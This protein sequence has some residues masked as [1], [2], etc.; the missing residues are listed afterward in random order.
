M[1]WCTDKHE[2][3]GHCSFPGFYKGL[4]ADI[5]MNASK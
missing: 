2:F 1:D 3:T 4:F 5:G